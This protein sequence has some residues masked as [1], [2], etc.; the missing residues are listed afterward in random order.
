MNLREIKRPIGLIHS[1]QNG[2]GEGK[3]AA[4]EG[5]ELRNCAGGSHR[6]GARDPPAATGAARARPQATIL[7]DRTPRSPGLTGSGLRGRGAIVTGGGRAAPGGRAGRRVGE[8][9]DGGGMA[10]A[11]APPLRDSQPRP[12]RPQM[13]LPSAA[14][15]CEAHSEQ[16]RVPRRPPSRAGPCRAG[17]PF[18]RGRT[19]RRSPRGCAGSPG[20]RCRFSRPRSSGWGDN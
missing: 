18:Q 17:R 10:G 11:V 1:A 6:G 2:C 19:A 5:Q 9:G 3:R 8:G 7:Q 15:L 13:A 14:P 16:R 12:L 20:L 4:Q